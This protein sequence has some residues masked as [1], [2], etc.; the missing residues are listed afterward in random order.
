MWIAKIKYE[1]DKIGILGKLAKKYDVTIIGYPVSSVKTKNG[2]KAFFVGTIY[3]DKK[4]KIKIFEEIKNLN[5]FENLE[6]NDDFIVAELK[7]SS[8]AEFLYDPK[9]IYARQGIIFPNGEEILEVT[10]FDRSELVDLFENLKNKAFGKL[11]SL[12]KES[13]SSISLVSIAPIIT[14]KQR[15]AF[16]LALAE[17]YYNH[18]RKTS[19]K[20][21][22][23]ISNVSFSAFHAHLRKAENTLLP[24]TYQKLPKM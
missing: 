24:Y 6:I 20:E 13:L 4:N 10:S 3:G 14:Q 19:I 1:A 22:A 2:L 9:I 18:P 17:G 12:K 8:D 15:D 5:F 23:K 16:E 11:I 7:V 21:L